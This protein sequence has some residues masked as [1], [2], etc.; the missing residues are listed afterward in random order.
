VGAVIVLSAAHLARAWVVRAFLFSAMAHLRSF[1]ISGRAKIL[2]VH[3]DLLEGPREK[4]SSR[5]DSSSNLSCMLDAPRKGLGVLLLADPAPVLRPPLPSTLGSS[6]GRKRHAHE[7][8]GRRRTT[9]RTWHYRDRTRAPGSCTSLRGC[10][11][12]DV[13]CIHACGNDTFR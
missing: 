8:N 5:Y 10:L 2:G 6:C 3:H 13:L 9:T 11:N 12:P 7:G 1:F 4:M